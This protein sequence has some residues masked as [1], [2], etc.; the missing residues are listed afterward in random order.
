[1]MH[2]QEQEPMASSLP[3]EGSTN[4]RDGQ[5]VDT[6]VLVASMDKLERFSLPHVHAQILSLSNATPDS[7]SNSKRC[8]ELRLR[9]KAEESTSARCKLCAADLELSEHTLPNSFKS[10]Q[11]Y[12]YT[13]T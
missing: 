9:E 11:A 13:H 5:N 12:T 2:E 10:T 4:L 7:Y 8:T 1:M 6:G 3:T